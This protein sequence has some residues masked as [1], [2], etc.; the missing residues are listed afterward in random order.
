MMSFRMTE[1]PLLMAALNVGP[2]FAAKIG[3][4]LRDDM[5]SFSSFY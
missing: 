4:L 3:D 1:L 2:D 5:V